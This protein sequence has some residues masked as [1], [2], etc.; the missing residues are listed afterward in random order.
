[1]FVIEQLAGL[2][3]VNQMPVF[4]E[5]TSDTVQAV[6]EESAKLTGEVIGPLNVVGDRDP[7]FWNADKTVTTT[8]GFKDAFKQYVDGGWQGLAISERAYQQAVTF[9]K[10]R[11]QS[12]D[13]S[14]SAGP[15]TIIHHP[16][17][18]RMLMTMRA[19]IEGGRAMAYL[20]AAYYDFAH[21]HPDPAVHGGMGFIEETGAAQHYRD[22]RILPIYEG[23]T[24]IQANDLVGRKTLRDGGKTAKAVCALIAKT[25]NDLAACTTKQAKDMAKQLG[26]ARQNLE[27][28]IDYV[29][30]NGKSDIKGRA[31]QIL[32]A[33]GLESYHSVNVLENEEIR[34]GI[35]TYAN[36]PTIPQLYIKGAIDES[37]FACGGC[38]LVI[39]IKPRLPLRKLINGLMAKRPLLWTLGL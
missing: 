29:V 28:V 26:L 25:E 5:A 19:T 23:T 36:W 3:Q 31:A 15:V 20:G 39:E 30:Q 16:D 6:L 32:Q 2:D 11:V 35:K 13:L 24:A 38:K 21:H 8:P 22:A 1:M 7:S 34:Q 12:R 17:V 27:Q 10:E 37:S 14:G 4:Q 33:C 9:A 18:K